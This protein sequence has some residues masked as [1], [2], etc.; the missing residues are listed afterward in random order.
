MTSTLDHPQLNFDFSVKGDRPTPETLITE[1]LALEKIAKKERRVYPLEQLI[2]TWQLTFITGTKKAQ[3]QAGK[4]LGKGRYLPSF[5]KVAIAY[6]KDSDHDPT[7]AWQKGTTINSVQVGLLNLTVSGPIKF[8]AK[9]RLLAFDFLQLKIKLGGL[10]LYS[11]NLRG[12]SEA[13]KTFHETPISKQPF[14]SY[15]YVS[16]NVI[17]ARGRGG[18][19]ALWTKTK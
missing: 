12:G 3:K 5:V 10:Q 18:G 16:D 1:L 17:A 19:V 8:H 15:F 9:K 2:G 13:A 14:F 6:T 7:A 11:G 4:T